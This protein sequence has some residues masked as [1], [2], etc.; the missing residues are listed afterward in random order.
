MTAPDR[1]TYGRGAWTSLGHA[2][3]TPYYRKADNKP[4]DG[5]YPIPSNESYTAVRLGVKAIQTELNAMSFQPPLVVDGLFGDKT[6]AAVK[7]AQNVLGVT[8]DGIVGPGTCKKLWRERISSVSKTY[9]LDP[10]ILYGQ[11]SHESSFDPGA[12]G[13][14]HPP[15]RGLVQINTETQAVTIEQAHDVS[16][17][18]DWSAKRL[19]AARSKYGAKGIEL[20]TWC[21]ILQHNSPAS[22]STLYR[23]G[24]FGSNASRDY[25]QSVLTAMQGW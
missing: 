4:A 6:T 12:V 19:F 24:E 22:A 2:C 18:L 16:F 21:L 3:N 5:A 25:T 1:S 20:Q 11:I 7:Q 9:G 14:V 17:A 8:S 13:Y 10:A 23:T 15:D